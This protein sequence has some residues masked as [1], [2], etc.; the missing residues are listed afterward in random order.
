MDEEGAAGSGKSTAAD[1]KGRESYS[2]L[3]RKIEELAD[4][5][6]VL[7]SRSGVLT[8]KVAYDASGWAVTPFSAGAYFSVHERAVDNFDELV[9][10]LERVARDPRAAV[11]RGRP[12]PGIDR[13]RCRRLCRREEHG[14]DVT[15]ESAARRWIAL[16]IDGVSE[17]ACTTFA[18]EPEAGVEHVLELL[19]E[20][21]AATSCYWQATSSAGVKSGIRARVWFWL[22]R[23]VSDAEARGWLASAPV[24]RSL[25]TPVALHYVAPPILAP[26][27]PSP[28]ARRSGTRRGLIDVVE[29]PAEL[30]SIETAVAV[31]VNLD[32]LAPTE[33]DLA[34]L[35][36]AV[37]RS[38]AARAIWVGERQFADRSSRHYSL[39]V[40]L[41]HAGLRDPDVLH[42][43]L[44]EHDRRVS[45]DMNKIARSDYVR[46]TIGAALAAAIS[47]RAAR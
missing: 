38:R 33:A 22:S 31:P 17:P 10:L 28:V 1:E 26:G 45:A 30:P 19:P 21:F 15:F 46:R 16:D 35:A 9:A 13:H 2:A 12:L 29:V 34:A 36:A 40:A 27:T 5:V 20:P 43:V 8:K 44:V 14:D 25:F 32:G 39:A 41:A 23:P 6:V 24:D 7:R 47:A 11:V 37:R 3:P 42:R 18:A 4:Q